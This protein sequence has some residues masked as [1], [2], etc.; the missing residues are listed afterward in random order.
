[1]E[2]DDKIYNELVKFCD[3]GDSMFEE[4]EYDTAIEW[5]EK[6]LELLPT[7][8][9]TWE[10]GTWIYTA[11]GD[12][13]FFKNEFEKSINYFYDAM[14][15]PEGYAN[16][17]ILMRVGQC[18]LELGQNEKAKDNLLRA[19]MMEGE[20]IFSDED[21]KYIEFIGDLI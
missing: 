19:Y 9:T 21:S 5:Y 15:C 13:Y 2:L 7:P 8:K 4:A 6:A 16:P 12:S 10:A 17:F 11:L 14:N 18:A 3:L 20:D 1:M